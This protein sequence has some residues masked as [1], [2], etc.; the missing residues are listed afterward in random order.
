VVFEPY[1]TLLSIDSIT[2][3]L[4]DH[5]DK[6]AQTAWRKYQLEHTWD[7]ADGS[8]HHG[9]AHAACAIVA[10][11][12]LDGYLSESRMGVPIAAS[13]DDVFV[14]GDYYFHISCQGNVEYWVMG[15][16]PQNLS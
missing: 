9:F 3:E 15:V 16:P 13:W 8:L 2:W 7:H 11:N 14:D 10:G 5:V 12:R 6:K 4:A 1:G